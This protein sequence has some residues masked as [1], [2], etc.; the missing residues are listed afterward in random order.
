MQGISPASSIVG[1]YLRR[2]RKLIE[3]ITSA[4]ILAGVV[5]FSGVLATLVYAGFRIT[6]K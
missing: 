6:I 4:L 3:H 1:V 5:S 2:W